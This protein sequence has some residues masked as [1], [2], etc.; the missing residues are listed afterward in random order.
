[1]ESQPASG[2]GSAAPSSSSRL[3]SSSS[4]LL[5]RRVLGGLLMLTTFLLCIF[6]LSD[7]DFWWHLR[8]GQLIV[9]R[10]AIPRTDWFL[11][12]DA[13]RPWIDLHWGFQLLMTGLYTLGGVNLVVLFKAAVIST[14]VGIGWFATGREAPAWLN[15]FIWIPA[16]ICISGR[17]F[18]RPEILSQLFLS[19][20]LW[21]AFRVEQFPRWIWILPVIQVVWINCHALYILGLVVGGCFA[22]DSLI[23]FLARGR[24]GLE[25][26]SAALQPRW[27]L[28][29][30]GLCAG[31][32]LINPYGLTG[33][34]FP[35]VLQRKF[36]DERLIYASIGEFQQP[37]DFFWRL[38]FGYEN[39]YLDAQ[40]LLAAAAFGSLLW[41]F[42]GYR[43]WSPF[44]WLLCLGF[45]QLA[46]AATRNV[47][48]FSLVFATV[49]AANAAELW[50]L[51]FAPTV[52]PAR[53]TQSRREGEKLAPKDFLS[54]SLSPPRSL[55][56]NAAAGVLLLLWITFTVTGRWGRLTGENK[57]FALGE[58]PHWFA[59]EAMQ[60]AGQ[61][62]FPNRAFAAHIG[63]AATYVF[64]NGPERKVFL[65]PR[66]EVARPETFLRHAQILQQMAV[67]DRRWELGLRDADKTLPVVILDSRNSRPS[68][69]GLL[70]T[71]GWRLVFADPAAAVFLTEQQADALK[72]PMADPLPL[73]YPP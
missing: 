28:G 1:M 68:I 40:I 4:L 52:K 25:P 35:L 9:E 73:M 44:R 14:A 34:L 71:P 7:T 58:R 57:P 62:E 42:V 41:L 45:G 30:G 15:V 39:V 59:H 31:A 67:G 46:W 8:T 11:F 55:L 61:P 36:A 17:G 53:E 48:I 47:N 38:K 10:G 37:I 16:V 13:D 66:L 21:I 63:L 56:P 69:T 23:R 19:L 5:S 26:L 49:T 6:P 3:F 43:R 12:T 27:V 60:F 2:P 65:D 54:P 70:N 20:W 32:A 29:A 72:L 18:E 24:W 64:H 33:A 22:I 50:R 51:W